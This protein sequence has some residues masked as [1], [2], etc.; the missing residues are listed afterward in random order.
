MEAHQFHPPGAGAAP[1]LGALSLLRGSS[2]AEREHG[3]TR[4]E[5]HLCLWAL[6]LGG[7]LHEATQS[8]GRGW[9]SPGSHRGW[10]HALHMEVN[11]E[12]AT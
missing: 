4:G 6:E 7:Q 5:G 3:D 2:R 1:S 11:L 8:K 10:G 9:L 12:L